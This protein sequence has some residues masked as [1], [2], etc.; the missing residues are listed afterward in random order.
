MTEELAQ[1]EYDYDREL[2]RKYLLRCQELSNSC[3]SYPSPKS[4][5]DALQEDASPTWAS[6]SEE[7]SRAARRKFI[8][9][10]EA[11][12]HEEVKKYHKTTPRE[13]WCN[14]ADDIK[15]ETNYLA[16][17]EETRRQRAEQIRL[18][19]EQREK[20]AL[21]VAQPPRA[22]KD[23]PPPHP[24]KPPTPRDRREYMASFRKRIISS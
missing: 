8:E 13:K 23:L 18:A 9:E 7:R 1:E 6:V 17:L 12:F 16:S 5:K 19:V 2:Y 11:D 22:P 24:V 4:C 14:D 10:R 20:R 21:L 15:K 3:G